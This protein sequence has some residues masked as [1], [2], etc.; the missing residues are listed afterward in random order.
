MDRIMHSRSVRYRFTLLLI[1]LLTAC[2]PPPSSIA[3]INATKS[4][5]Q[6]KQELKD[7]QK[8]H[9]SGGIAVKEG[10]EGFSGSLDWR[11]TGPT[12]YTIVIAGPLGSGKIKMTA[13]N[14]HVTLSDGSTTAHS[15]NAST[16]IK[17]QTGY[18]IPISSL[19]Y[20]IRG[21][22]AP[23]ASAQKSFDQFGHLQ[24]LRQIGW[25]IDYKRFTAFKG[26]D[27]PSKLSA[28][29]GNIKVKIVVNQWG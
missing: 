20:W 8:W 25:Q 22:P 4:F 9:I 24:Q 2:A 29:K 6:R 11:Q 12:D 13:N 14:G 21:L 15:N 19:F 23:N 1:S 3:P 26:Y 16:L 18:S 28:I 17:E 10:H 27:V 5:E 7:I